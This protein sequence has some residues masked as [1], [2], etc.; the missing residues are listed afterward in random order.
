MS[1][2]SPQTLSATLKELMKYDDAF[3]FRGKSV[4]IPC[5]RSETRQQLLLDLVGQ[6]AALVRHAGR[7]EDWDED[8][9]DDPLYVPQ[10]VFTLRSLD[11][12]GQYFPLNKT[13]FPPHKNTKSSVHLKGFLSQRSPRSQSQEVGDDSRQR[14]LLTS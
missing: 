6:G 7:V 11:H 8:H 2:S 14:S 4:T 12:S 9:G 3:I 5:E 13:I 1:N 10:N